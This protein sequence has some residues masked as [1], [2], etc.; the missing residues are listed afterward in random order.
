LQAA[1]AG[2]GEYEL[3]LTGS[4]G[5][6]SQTTTV[7]MTVDVTPPSVL[8]IDTSGDLLRG[9][10][11]G[12]ALAFRF[13]EPIVSGNV[14]LAL[15]GGET[16]AVPFIADGVEGVGDKQVWGWPASANA[17]G[18]YMVTATY[19]DAFGNVGEMTPLSFL[20]DHQPPTATV[21]VPTAPSDRVPGVL[22][23]QVN[24]NLALTVGVSVAFDNGGR[25]VQMATTTAT[26]NTGVALPLP[27]GLMGPS[28]PRLGYTVTLRDMADNVAVVTGSVT[29]DRFAPQVTVLSAVTSGNVMVVKLRIKDIDSKTPGRVSVRLM[30]KKIDGKM[31]R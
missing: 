14:R 4:D 16:V 23:M 1:F 9:L 3:V 26:V 27:V 8:H 17:E 24:D 31:A 13:S 21:S 7:S 5:T 2:D 6:N 30:D 18:R 29:V 15:E 20:I 22:G 25:V 12:G 10:G 19:A 11:G 28:D